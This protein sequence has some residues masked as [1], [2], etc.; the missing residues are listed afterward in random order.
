[1][2]ALFC[3]RC[4]SCQNPVI[5]VNFKTH[6]RRARKEK[7]RARRAIK[8]NKKTKFKNSKSLS[9]S[10]RVHACTRETKKITLKK[11]TKLSP[12]PPCSI[13]RCVR[14]SPNRTIFSR[15]DVNPISVLLFFFS[16]EAG[17]E[18]LFCHHAKTPSPIAG[19]KN[20]K[21][22]KEKA[23]DEGGQKKVDA[24]CS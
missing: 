11:R 2:V 13:D 19:A 6:P 8:T 23:A 24:G 12:H 10:A 16:E 9:L 5:S 21:T 7:T 14:E 15:R 17:G 3:F 1:M 4:C 20:R 18:I 22:A